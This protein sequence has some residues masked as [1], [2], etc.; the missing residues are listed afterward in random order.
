[1]YSFHLCIKD[2]RYIFSFIIKHPEL[3]VFG[4]LNGV[5]KHSPMQRL[6]ALYIGV[7]TCILISTWKIT[8]TQSQSVLWDRE[9]KIL[10][11]YQQMV[12][13][14]ACKTRVML[15]VAPLFVFKLFKLLC[16]CW[17]K[18]Y[19]HA[20]AVFGQL[21]ARCTNICLL[22]LSA[23]WRVR[24]DNGDVVD[25]CLLL[26]NGGCGRICQESTRSS[27]ICKKTVSWF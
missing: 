11:P 23:S 22:H 15:R 13:V 9:Q 5:D 10:S 17:T 14:Y 7:S 4:L 6:Q 8:K 21:V 2:I 26:L 18:L 20:A 19:L 1:M 25:E 3:A 24:P 27:N 12:V 16:T